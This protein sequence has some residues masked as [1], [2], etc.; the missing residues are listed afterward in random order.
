MAVTTAGRYIV[1]GRPSLLVG[2]MRTRRCGT[3]TPENGTR[4]T[5]NGSVLSVDDTTTREWRGKVGMSACCARQS[6]DTVNREPSGAQRQL[7]V[8]RDA[9]GL[10]GA[11]ARTLLSRRSKCGC[12]SG[13]G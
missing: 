12:A 13:T 8:A 6:K 4:A 2:S 9:S 5:P 1:D 10:K 7:L 3:S 11:V